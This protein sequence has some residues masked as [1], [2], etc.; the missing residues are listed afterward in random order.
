MEQAAV[1]SNKFYYYASIFFGVDQNQTSFEYDL[2]YEDERD[3]WVNKPQHMMNRWMQWG[4]LTI[5]SLW[6][7]LVSKKLKEEFIPD[8]QQ[9]ANRMLHKMSDYSQKLK[10]YGN[11][12]GN[13]R[14]SN[15]NNDD[16]DIWVKLQKKFAKKRQQ[17]LT[18]QGQHQRRRFYQGFGLDD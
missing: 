14:N 3:L 1:L 8:L 13:S 18:N 5:I 11:F 4:V 6:V 15:E 2:S 7:R 9:T 16:D 12:Y 17:Q 10:N